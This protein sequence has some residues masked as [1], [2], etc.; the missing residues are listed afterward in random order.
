MKILVFLANGCEDVEAI[1]VIDYLRRADIDVTTVSIHDTND[2]TTKSNIT[3]TADTNLNDIDPKEFDGL[4]IPGGTK[5]AE[6]LR[7]DDRVVDIVK[8]FNDEEKLIAAICA[9][10][11]VLNK[12]G[13]LA[14]KRATSF[15]DLKDDID[16]IL[17]YVDD[18]M[19]VTDGNIT[20]SCGAAVTVY[21]AMRL[22]EIIKGP[23]AVEE[24]KHGTQLECVEDYYGISYDYLSN[25]GVDNESNK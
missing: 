16:N 17:E 25:D 22:V 18:Q 20:T 4:Y 11:I 9:G 24:L 10:P 7:D 14:D 19:V 21:L 5:G 2:I 23:E 6:A 8:T 15:P 12:A 1:T 3:L 13:V